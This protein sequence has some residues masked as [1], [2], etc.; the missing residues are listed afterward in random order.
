[1]LFRFLIRNSV[2]SVAD[3]YP[4]LVAYLKATVPRCAD[5]GAMSCGVETIAWR[6]SFTVRK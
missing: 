3:D 4:K 6:S 1:M 5:Y 2:L